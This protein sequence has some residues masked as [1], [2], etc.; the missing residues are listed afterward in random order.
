MDNKE[1]FSQN[2]NYYM[3]LFGK[4][5]RDVADAIDVS[6]FTFTDW[7]KGKTYPRMGKVERLAKYF[8]IKIS[9]LVEP[10]TI[11]KKP[12]ESA[13]LHAKILTDQQ[14]ME[15]IEEYF[16]LSEENQQMVRNLVRNLQ[17][18]ED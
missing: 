5:R 18:R 11:E 15:T 16:L 10:R 8:G 3:N 2:L 4:T 12:V 6:Y 17:K 13:M 9:D 7:A 14:L 1:I